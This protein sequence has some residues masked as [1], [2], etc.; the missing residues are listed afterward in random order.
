MGSAGEAKDRKLVVFNLHGTLVDSSLLADKNPNSAI[1][2]TVTTE[3]RR[4]TFRPWLV[5]FLVRCF[6][7]FNVAFWGSK[8]EVYM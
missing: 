1:R 8:S 5:K 3:N 6:L 4:V 7:N 2:A